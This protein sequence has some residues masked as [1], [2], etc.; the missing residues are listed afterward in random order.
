MNGI[1]IL[2]WITIELIAAIAIIAVK[3]HYKGDKANY[4]ILEYLAATEHLH[5]MHALEAAGYIDGAGKQDELNKRIL[6][7]VPYPLIPTEQARHLCW[8][9]VKAALVSKLD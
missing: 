8:L 4:S 9:A 7:L 6:N 2:I 1:T 5:W 3:L